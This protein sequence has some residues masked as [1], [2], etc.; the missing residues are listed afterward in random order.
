VRKKE[1]I[2]IFQLEYTMKLRELFLNIAT[3][4]KT[5]ADEEAGISSVFIRYVLVNMAVIFGFFILLFFAGESFLN[6]SYVDAVLNASMAVFCLVSFVTGR[7]MNI[8]IVPALFSVLT[9]PFLCIGLVING[10]AQGYGF[11]WIYMYPVM[12]TLILGLV[13]GI[14]LSLFLII[15]VFVIVTVPGLSNHVY[16]FETSSRLIVAYFM[17]MGM[18]IV[19]EIARKTKENAIVNLTK[20]L[21]EQ[22]DNNAEL[23]EKADAASAAKSSF[24]ATMS[25]EIRTPM[26]AII[27]MS[28]LLLRQDL[29]EESYKNATDIKQAGS[30]LL[31]IINDILDFSKIESGKL[32]IIE[33]EYM[34][35]SV[36]NDC[37]NI[38]QNRIAEKPIKFITK[39]DPT[40]PCTLYGDMIRI[41]QVCLNLLSNAAKYT[42]EGSITFHVSGTAREDRQILLSFEVIDTGIGIKNEDMGK[43]F[44]DFSQ[45][46]THRN[47]GIEGTG[48]GLAITR[49]LC[50]LMGGDVAVQSVYRQGSAFTAA[51]PQRVVDSR[52]IGSVEVPVTPYAGKN[53]VDLKFTA[54]DARI[55]AVDDIDT[56]LTV[57][58]GLLAP[59]QMKITICTSGADAIN[60]MKTQDFDFVL[61]DH[62]M[63][64]MDGI[65]ATAIIRSLEPPKNEIPVIALT[66]NAVSGMKEMFL[67]KGFNDYISK[68]IEI[69]KLDELMAK[70]IPKEKQIKTGAEFVRVNSEN[71]G[72]MFIPGID[73]ARGIRMTGGTITGYR[74]VLSSFYKDAEIRLPRIQGKDM[75]AFI[76]NVH[77]L[78]SAAGAI[79]AEELS[80]EAAALEAAGKA[81]DINAIAEKLPIF[82]EHLKKTADKIRAAL[83]ASALAASAQADTP[84]L[85]VRD[86]NI[87]AFVLKLRAALEVKDMAEID[88]VTGELAAKG[89]DKNTEE[90]LNSISDLLLVAKFKQALAETENLLKE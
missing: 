89:L 80:R 59:Y 9:Y 54:P 30:N 61:M 67:E 52:P 39:V 71:D 49:Q 46:D 7:V 51:I 81:G 48:L 31:S 86:P 70:W 6:D 85:D 25:H 82:C 87:R 27:G 74:R 44:G 12:S 11:V 13:A 78:K 47:R 72:G 64:E 42:Q 23:R 8:S 62:M 73:I 57:L 14:G 29:P 34:L 55:L 58:K 18:T 17:V 66:A 35:A 28:E 1:D 69:P 40:L 32:D 3:S 36:I 53:Q 83:A 41:R 24:L 21:K 60:L 20:I 43:L 4:G 76:I 65:E 79:G 37:I 50:H 63:P 84:L 10:A 5:F 68:P 38:I 15:A 26:N 75:S 77:A 90:A 45:V 33:A 16:T 19:F 22:R 2:V 56:N 88:R